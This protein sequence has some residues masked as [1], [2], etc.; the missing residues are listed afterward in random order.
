M[1]RYPILE[2]A[3]FFPLFRKYVQV[4]GNKRKRASGDKPVFTLE[5]Y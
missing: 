5:K 1:G 4:I 2:C 3:I